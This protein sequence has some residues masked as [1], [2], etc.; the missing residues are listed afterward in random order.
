MQD[1]IKN[2]ETKFLKFDHEL[3]RIRKNIL[4]ILASPKTDK[5]AIQKKHSLYDL[6]I[7]FLT[8]EIKRLDIEINRLRLDRNKYDT[9]TLF[10]KVLKAI[11][12]KNRI[13]KYI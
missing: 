1:R 13:K 9:D 10:D 6:R 4:A 7:E 5:D 2:V 12:D 11:E 3:D 8:K